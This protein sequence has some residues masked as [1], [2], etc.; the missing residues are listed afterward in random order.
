MDNRVYLRAQGNNFYYICSD[1]TCNNPIGT[2]SSFNKNEF[3]VGIDGD[4]FKINFQ[5]SKVS[6]IL[7]EDHVNYMLELWRRDSKTSNSNKSKVAEV[8][9]P[10]TKTTHSNQMSI[11]VFDMMEAIWGREALM[12]FCEMNEFEYRMRMGI[13]PE[14]P[15]EAYLKKYSELKSKINE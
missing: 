2:V 1:V 6:I 7:L 8:V 12:T 14:Q 4:S 13:K 11:E 10:T 9:N 15:I 3:N 5:T